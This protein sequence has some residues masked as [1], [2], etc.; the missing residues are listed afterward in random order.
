MQ[1]L[2]GQVVHTHIRKQYNIWFLETCMGMGIKGSLPDSGF[3]RGCSCKIVL[4]GSHTDGNK[5]SGTPVGNGLK[6]CF[7]GF[8]QNVAVKQQILHLAQNFVGRG[9]L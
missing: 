3:P 7:K 9:K 1:V 5:C 8:L 2:L 4:Q 6:K